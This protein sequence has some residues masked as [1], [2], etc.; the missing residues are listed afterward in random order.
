MRERWKR[1]IFRAV[2]VGEVPAE[3]EWLGQIA[4]DWNALFGQFLRVS[5]LEAHHDKSFSVNRHFTVQFAISGLKVV[6]SAVKHL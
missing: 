1:R 3:L 6:N 4:N 2:D 5:V